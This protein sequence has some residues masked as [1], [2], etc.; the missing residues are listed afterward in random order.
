MFNKNKP[1]RKKLGESDKK[2][3]IF[4][5]LVAAVPVVQFLIFYVYVN[6]NSIIMAFQ[7]YEIDNVTNL[8]HYVGNGF[9]N[10][11]RAFFELTRDENMLIALK[12]SCIYYLV[13]VL[14]G[15]TVSLVFSYYIYKKK[16]CA[17]FFKVMLFLP[18]IL[19]A[20]VLIIMFKYFANFAIP[21]L[22]K[23]LF[24]V[25]IGSLLNTEKTAFGTVLFYNI[26]FGF[27][28]SVLIYLGTMNG[29][30]DSLVEAAELDG[31]NAFQEFCHVTFPSVYPTV[32]TF[33]IT[34]LAAFFTADMGLYSFFSYGAAYR[35]QT[36][37]YYL[38]KETRAASFAEYPYLSALGLIFTAITIP[39]TIILRRALEKLG[40]SVD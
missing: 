3:I 15:I 23:K 36:I 13:S 35:V 1:A 17:S 14:V 2:N 37:G 24:G 19:S 9:A 4:I 34:N 26:W 7:R 38:L 18:S 29:I 11:K 31:A 39:L 27:G 40:P 5:C 25:K 16:P 28:S 33:V 12:N 22:M 8:G 10:F 6:I 20:I 32:S 21:E 30:S